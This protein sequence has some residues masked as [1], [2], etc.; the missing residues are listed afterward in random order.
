MW[1]ATTTTARQAICGT[2]LVILGFNSL[3]LNE[4]ACNKIA[5]F[6]ATTGCGLREMQAERP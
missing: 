1:R 4:Y 2:G 3:F 6:V 5:H